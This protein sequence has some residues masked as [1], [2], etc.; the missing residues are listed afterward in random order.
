MTVEA[1]RQ[2][3]LLRRARTLRVFSDGAARGNP[4]P[5]GAGAVLAL[6]S[7]EVVERLGLYLGRQTN[8]HAE[9]MGAILGLKRARALGA[10]EVE[11]VTDSQLLIRQLA[12]QYRVR[13]PT[14]R[15]LYE[16]AHALLE[17]F[18][19]HLLTHV[20]REENREADVMSNRAI[21]ER[22]VGTPL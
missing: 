22:L 16:E 20:P 5:A 19:R 17:A 14:L 13:S 6:P 21:D 1:P 3:S 9:Y 10:D 11:L 4:G 18:Q 2:P 7:G 15:P 12:G 8:N